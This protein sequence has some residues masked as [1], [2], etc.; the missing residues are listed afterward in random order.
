M[1]VQ[2]N[3][4]K[5]FSSKDYNYV[6][7]TSKGFFARW[8]NKIDDDPELSSFGP[9]ILDIEV[10]TICTKAC[11]HCYKSNTQYGRNMTFDTFKEIFHKFPMFNGKHFLTQIAFGIGDIDS[12]P[13]LWNMMSYITHFGVVPNITINGSKLTT[14]DAQ[15]LA[16]TCGAVSVSCYDFETCFNAVKLLTD[17][18]VKQVNIHQLL[19]KDNLAYCSTLLDA[20]KKDTRLKYLNSIVFL[21]LK[22]KGKR[23]TLV[24]ITA[25]NDYKALVDKA[26]A[27]NVKIG[28]D[29]CSASS[30]LKS[31][32]HR[33]DYYEIAKMVEPCESTLFSYYI[34]A[35]GIGYP[36][37]FAEGLP[38]FKGIDILKAQDFIKDV[39]ENEETKAFRQQL[40]CN[41][42]RNMC[43]TC[44]IYKLEMS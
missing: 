17:N 26:F 1:I 20:P 34:N 2:K 41:K 32:K 4:I 28:F 24:Q 33:R 44:Q 19:S 38:Q 12:N 43:R 23:N 22:P 25:L 8:G 39:W 15:K 11:T 37:S 7:D 6:F 14:K 13:D 35:S 9:E 29:S 21:L 10:S 36:C 3:S 31:I 42:D 5:T 27:N 40:I 16:L 18:G 30:F